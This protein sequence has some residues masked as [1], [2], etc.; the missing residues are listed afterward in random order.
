[1]SNKKYTEETMLK[2]F[3]DTVNRLEQQKKL[4]KQRRELEKSDD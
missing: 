2:A 3:P 4:K 1:M